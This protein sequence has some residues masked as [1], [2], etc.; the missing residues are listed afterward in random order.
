MAS[1]LGGV[2]S[3]VTLVNFASF[4]AQ[5][6]TVAASGTPVQLPSVVVPDGASVTIRAKVDNNNKKIYLADSSANTALA[7]NR[8]VLRA[9]ESVEMRLQNINSVWIDSNSNGAQVEVLAE[10]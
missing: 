5:V 4:L 7:S 1:I 3:V 6:V 10:Q 9:G 2:Q 8:L